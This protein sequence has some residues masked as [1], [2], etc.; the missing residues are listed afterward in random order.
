VKIV[1][2]D[3]KGSEFVSFMVDVCNTEKDKIKKKNFMDNQI[4]TKDCSEYVI[5]S[6]G[7]IEKAIHKEDFY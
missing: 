7:F 5:H 3:V 6:L 4:T 2:G 1:K